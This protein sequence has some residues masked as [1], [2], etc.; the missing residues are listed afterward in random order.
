MGPVSDARGRFRMSS[1]AV[2]RILLALL[3]LTAAGLKAHQLAT[4]PVVGTFFA[5]SRLFLICLVEL[6]LLLGLWLLVGGYPKASWTVALLSFGLFAVVSLYKALSGAASCDCF[7][8]IEV[9]PWYTLTLDVAVIAALLGCRPTSTTPLDDERRTFNRIR[10]AFVA[11]LWLSVALPTGLAMASFTP[12][13]VNAAGDFVGESRIVVVEPATWVGN[14]FPLLEHIDVGEKISEGKWTLLLYHDDCPSC[15]EAIARLDALTQATSEGAHSLQVALIEVPPYGGSVRR[16]LS[17]DSTMVLGR[18]NNAREWFIETP[19][20]ISLDLGEVLAVVEREEKEIPPA[21]DQDIAF[22]D[23]L[24]DSNRPLLGISRKRVSKPARGFPD[25]REA[26]RQ[27]RVRSL[28]CGPLAL[29]AVCNTLGVELTRDEEE[30]MIASAGARGTSLLQLQHLTEARGLHALGIEVAPE[31]LRELSLPAIVHFGG[32]TFAAL[33]DYPRDG[34]E[35][36]LP[37]KA[38][39]TMNEKQFLARFGP[40]GRALL[41]SR[42][43]ISART[44]GLPKPKT[45]SPD[46]PIIRLEQSM[47]HLGLLHTQDWRGS[48]TI[49]NDGTRPLIIEDTKTA[50]D[51]MTAVVDDTSIPPGGSTT[52]R[53]VG[54]K[55]KLGV[56]TI[57]TLLVTNQ[58]GRPVVEIPVGGCIESP[59]FLE[60]PSVKFERLAP[61]E[62]AAKAVVIELPQGFSASDIAITIPEDA[63]VAAETIPSDD[64]SVLLVARWLGTD[65]PGWHGYS[66][67]LGLKGDAK[68]VSATLLLAAQVLPEVEAFPPSLLIRD[69]ELGQDWSRRVELRVLRAL[70]GDVKCAWSRAEFAEHLETSTSTERNGLVVVNVSPKLAGAAE[71]LCGNTAELEV[72]TADGTMAHR[73]PIYVGYESILNIATPSTTDSK[74]ASDGWNQRQTVSLK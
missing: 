37:E 2:L 21:D 7:G 41:V 56:F 22:A 31:A 71:N 14:Q 50:C 36:V 35:V 1:Y 38:P 20:E 70:E 69:S 17:P 43:P 48:L 15:E 45:P 28:A 47:I 53:I 51:C 12:A 10:A 34:Y 73:V 61:G 33:I 23:P 64:G 46:A 66:I 29:I 58:P 18:L 26:R 39:Q 54:T 62:S 4:E 3:I 9:N 11:C 74:E 8:K 63:P 52:L 25:Y 6:E 44:T 24:A 19:V 40:R 68:T 72:S 59:V 27:R 30:R 13:T 55:R 42:R 60:R 65:E 57:K 5:D 16:L 67:E 49:H 32:G